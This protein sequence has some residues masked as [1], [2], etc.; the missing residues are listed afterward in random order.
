MDFLLPHSL[1]F[2]ST[3]LWNDHY[4]GP[5]CLAYQLALEPPVQPS[6]ASVSFGVDS[7]I[8]LRL[9]MYRSPSYHRGSGMCFHL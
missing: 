1:L 7:L 6:H 4:L 3:Q 9:P 2:L 5:P 8:L